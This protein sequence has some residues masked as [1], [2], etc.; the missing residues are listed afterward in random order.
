MYW[1][2]RV[3]C[4][5]GQRLTTNEQWYDRKNKYGQVIS[6]FQRY[7]ADKDICM[8]CSLALE[9]L[10]NC[11]PKRCKKGRSIERSQYE[12]AVEANRKRVEQNR[13]LYR[14]RQAIVEHPFGTIKRA[15]GSWG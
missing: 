10:A 7:I 15:W 14:R 6:S 11:D 4:P 5:A 1:Q 2:M 12:Q 8:A 3:T 9:C 13:D